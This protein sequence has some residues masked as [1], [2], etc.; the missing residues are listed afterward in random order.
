MY[1]NNRTFIGKTHEEIVEKQASKDVIKLITL[2]HD[3]E[4]K[5]NAE[6]MLDNMQ[7][8]SKIK[9]IRH[10]EKKKHLQVETQAA[11]LT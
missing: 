6:K 7:V 1:C 2:L 9:K 3:T 10:Y 8:C 11:K 5:Q 4:N